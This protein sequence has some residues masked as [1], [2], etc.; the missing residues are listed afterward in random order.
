MSITRLE[1]F[2]FGLLFFISCGKDIHEK[3]FDS[4]AVASQDDKDQGHLQN[5]PIMQMKSGFHASMVGFMC[6]VLIL[7]V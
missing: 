2:S 5:F 1:L 3:V 6:A 4:P 7:L